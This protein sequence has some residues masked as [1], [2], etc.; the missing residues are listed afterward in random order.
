MTKKNLGIIVASL[1]IAV[2]FGGF[3]YSGKK[4][5]A[6]EAIAKQTALEN[7]DKQQTQEE[8]A[9]QA[10]ANAPVVSVATSAI[11]PKEPKVVA[12]VPAPTTQ[13]TS[14]AITTPTTTAKEQTKPTTPT[15]TAPTPTPPAPAPAPTISTE[16]VSAITSLSEADIQHLQSYTQ[17]SGNNG[18]SSAYNSFQ[19]LYVVERA[20]CDGLAKDFTPIT[21]GDY[22]KAKAVWLGSPKL[23]YRN[24]ISQYCIRGILTLTYYGDNK[25]SLAPNVTY[26][27]EVEYRLRYTDQL[28]LEK[29]VYLTE[30]KAVK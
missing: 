29:T 26:Q 19:D 12:S 27:R 25:F 16:T 15:P 10:K 28:R 11:V 23:I 6:K 14:K 13:D 2:S 30:F 4:A 3:V 18:V 7:I 17:Y 5:D 24:A 8:A 22:S 21:L 20:S 1:I 9:Y